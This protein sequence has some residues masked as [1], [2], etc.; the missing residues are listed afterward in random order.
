M[1]IALQAVGVIGTRVGRILSA[2]AELAALGLYGDQ[3]GLAQDRRTLRISSLD[4]FNALVTD[5]ETSAAL[6]LAALAVEDGISCAIPGAINDALG[7]RFETAGKTVMANCSLAG[8]AETLAAHEAARTDSPIDTVIAWT[9]SGK[10]IR[11]GTPVAF[12]DPVGARWGR[13]LGRAH[14]IARVSVPIDGPWAGATAIVVGTNGDSTVSRIVGVADDADHLRAIAL[15]AGAVTVTQT[16]KV[17]RIE[18]R[19]VAEQYLAAALG[20]GLG[21]ATYTLD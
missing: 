8:L 18:P 21:V 20:M 19:D 2:E 12:P 11:R 4:G 10:P 7:L 13:R 17:G 15:A 14:G 5:D 6:A 3:A 1:R 9:E 16:D